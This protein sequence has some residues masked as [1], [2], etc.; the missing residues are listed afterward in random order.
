MSNYIP[1]IK[2]I[3]FTSNILDVKFDVIKSNYENQPKFKLGYNTI[4]FDAKF[5]K[6]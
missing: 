6:T 2:K 4:F 1:Y 3:N 5:N